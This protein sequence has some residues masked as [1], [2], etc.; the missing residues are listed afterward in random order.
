MMR[1]HYGARRC[2]E[3]TGEL[4][5]IHGPALHRP[6]RARSGRASGAADGLPAHDVPVAVWEVH[7]TRG[8]TDGA[9]GG[10]HRASGVTPP[11]LPVGRARRGE[12]NALF[13]SAMQAM[14]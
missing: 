11:R 2:F 4:T 5:P 8:A 3:V 10:G 6:G 1:R 12:E 9:T 14:S 7:A 13:V